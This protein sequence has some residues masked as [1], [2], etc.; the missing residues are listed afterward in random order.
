MLKLNLDVNHPPIAL[1]RQEELTLVGKVLGAVDEDGIAAVGNTIIVGA[2]VYAGAADLRRIHLDRDIDFLILMPLVVGRAYHPER[3]SSDQYLDGIGTQVM[4]RT[5]LAMMRWLRSS[6]RA[7]QS[8]RGG[9]QA[10]SN[11]FPVLHIYPPVAGGGCH[12]LL[13]VEIQNAWPA[14]KVG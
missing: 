10:D 6:G 7:R 1:H 8:Q 3:E 9:D 4:A 12:P 13:F 2:R 11:Y 5:R 14:G